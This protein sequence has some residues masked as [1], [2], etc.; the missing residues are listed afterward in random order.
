MI[1]LIKVKVNHFI[2]P[3]LV[4]VNHLVYLCKRKVKTILTINNYEN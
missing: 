3:F 4:Y 2:A 1:Y